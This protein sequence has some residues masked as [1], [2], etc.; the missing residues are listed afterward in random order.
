MIF[1]QLVLVLIVPSPLHGGCKDNKNQSRVENLSQFKCEKKKGGYLS[2]TTL[3]ETYEEAVQSYLNE[4][5]NGC[6]QGFLNFMS[7]YKN[8]KNAVVMCRRKCRIESNTNIPMFGENIE[9]L[10]FYEKSIKQTLCILK[11]NQEYRVH[12]G[13]NALKR[14]SQ[15]QESKIIFAEYYE[16]LHICYFQRNNYQE[17]AN[18]IFT[19]LIYHP[20]HKPSKSNLAFYMKH[21]EVKNNMIRNLHT[22]P[23]I[24]DYI[25]GIKA[26]KKE[27]YDNAVASF[28]NS[29]I[30][31]IESEESCRFYC[32]GPLDYDWNPEFITAFSNHFVYNLHCKRRCA[33][34]LQ[35]LNGEYQ[36]DFLANH[37]NYLQ[38][39]YYQLHD[40]K[41]ACEAVASYL[42]FYPADETMLSNKDYYASLPMIKQNDFRP[43]Q[44]I[45]A[46]VSRQEY[47]KRL[48][49]YIHKEF[50]TF[51]NNLFA[52][53]SASN[54]QKQKQK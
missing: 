47:E 26:Y 5:W 40:I 32:E 31:Y 2:D 33:R 8:Y 10:H 3:L 22:E 36:Q 38:F 7:K 27:H 48:L 17:A 12:A 14:L 44:D 23:F 20:D 11:C 45:L 34:F 18:A 53:E 4:D 54:Q 30:S 1:L 42:L 46:Y 52:S 50:T 37:F 19:Y 16:Y 9:D 13:Q 39:S 6:I 49:L 21:P 29:I 24:N 43:R 28:E 35:S 51:E 15:K 41:M 25:K